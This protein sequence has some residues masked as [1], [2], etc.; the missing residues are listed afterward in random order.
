MRVAA[1]FGSFSFLLPRDPRDILFLLDRFRP[2][3][4]VLRLAITG[5]ILAQIAQGASRFRSRRPSG[6]RRT[7]PASYKRLGH[8]CGR[9]AMFTGEGTSTTSPVGVR[10]PVARSIFK[11]TML[12]DNWFSANRYLPLGSIAKCRG[13]LPPVG[14]WATN[15]S[16]D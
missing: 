11:T 7:A 16:V 1:S 5:G 10:P 4:F 15:V 9:K 2:V 3:L 13:S 14:T 6:A 12:F 8:S